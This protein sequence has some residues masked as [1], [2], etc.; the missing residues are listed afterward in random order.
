MLA[1]RA[2]V[3][4]AALF[5]AA[6]FSSS[7]SSAQAP[8]PDKEMQE[9]LSAFEALGP[10]PIETLTPAEARRQPT[11]AD[12][13]KAVLQKNGK[14][15][16]PE[17]VAKVEDRTIKGAGGEIPIR[18][19]WPAGAKAEGLPVVHYIHGGGWVIA[20]LDVYDA[21]P[22][23]IA[24]AAN[25]IVV[26]SHYRQAPEHKFP[27]AHEDSFAAYQWVLANAQAL[28]G[29][30]QAV[31]VMGESAGGNM[32]AA[33]TMMAKQKRVQ[34]PVHQVLVYPVVNYAFDTPSYQENADAKPL[35]KAGM[36]WFFQ[37]YLKSE[38][39]GANPM[40]SL[41]KAK[42]LSGLPSATVITA[43]IDPL[44]SEGKAYADKLKQAGVKVDY[45]N[46]EGVAHE[47]FGMGA[48]VPDAKQ[49]VKQAAGGLRGSFETM[50]RGSERA[51][52]R[53]AA[54]ASAK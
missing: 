12:A 17:P 25:A 36:Q 4:V 9:V 33:I 42:D 7:P 32:A 35:G 8:K 2:A 10:K 31:A 53:A 20:D 28:G 48:V 30:P 34:M 41:L 26:S 14:S 39:D 22:R 43:Q 52:R 21:S 40:L 29:D 5:A 54:G 23:A 49:A 16:D 19:Y 45:R 46:Y 24:N 3:A 51:Q 15:T 44:R 50:A 6:T 13:V 47:F 11:P 27:A 18:I 37:H 1:T 38:K